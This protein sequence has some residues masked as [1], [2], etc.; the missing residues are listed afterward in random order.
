MNA[1]IAYNSSQ[2]HTRRLAESI[3]ATLEE[4]G[5]GTKTMPMQR[6]SAAD[7]ESADLLFIGTWAQGLFVVRV[8]PA[9]V[10]HWLPGLPDLRGKPT[11]AFTTYRF[12]P[13]G[14]LRELTSGLESRGATVVAARAFR[15][16]RLDGVGQL[17]DEALAAIAARA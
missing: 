14:M 15:R 1:A 3:A 17:V 4:R 2:G 13:A 16:D 10:E 5:V 12:R 9:G 6:L 8:R 11:V 7:V